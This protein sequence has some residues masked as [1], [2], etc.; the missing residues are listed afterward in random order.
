MS[1]LD[2]LVSMATY[3]AGEMCRPEVVA[4]EVPFLI[5]R[6]GRHPCVIQTYLGGDFIPN[7]IIINSD[8]VWAI[9]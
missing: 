4:S 6:E 5:I 8:R 7:D 2:V 3:S 9:F 1:I